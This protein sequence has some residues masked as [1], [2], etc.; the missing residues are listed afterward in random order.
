MS[1]KQIHVEM[2]KKAKQLALDCL[3]SNQKLGTLKE[4]GAYYGVADCYNGEVFGPVA[5]S[6][7]VYWRETSADRW[8]NP[9]RGW[10]YINQERNEVAG[11]SN[12]KMDDTDDELAS[13]TLTK[14]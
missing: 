1:D 14:P 8:M 9:S 11:G 6:R 7:Q 4:R 12:A 3:N 5:T 13:L 10:I 2:S